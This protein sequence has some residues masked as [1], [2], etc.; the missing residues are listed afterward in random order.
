MV[1]TSLPQRPEGLP[2]PA[3][4]SSQASIDEGEASLEDILANISPIAAVSGSDSTSTSM[5]LTELQTNANKALDD[6]LSTK[7]SIDARRLRAVWDLGVLLHQTE[8]QAAATVQEARTIHSQT[9]LGIWM[10][11]SQSILEAKTGYLVAVK[12]AKTT[13]S[14]LLQEANVTC[15]KVICEAEAQKMSQVTMLHKEHGKYM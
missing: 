10:A 5:D 15:S 8:S 3:D 12:E 13:R 11:C 1:L 14:H 6:L 7:G 2:L 9:A 4:T